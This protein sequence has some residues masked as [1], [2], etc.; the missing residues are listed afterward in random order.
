MQPLV[1]VVRSDVL[2]FRFGALSGATLP[3]LQDSEADAAD[4]VSQPPS[5]PRRSGRKR[6]APPARRHRG[7][8]V[9]RPKS[10]SQASSAVPDDDD[11]GVDSGVHSSNEGGDDSDASRGTRRRKKAGA[12]S[13]KKPALSQARV[14]KPNGKSRCS[15]CLK[16]EK[17]PAPYRLSSH[18]LVIDI[19]G[20]SL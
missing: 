16:T 6:Q 1:Q 8:A 11:G 13:A 9:K 20:H 4:S 10:E 18:G 2:D 15:W 7:S 17:D 19:G 14:Q 12:Q 5:P 3:A